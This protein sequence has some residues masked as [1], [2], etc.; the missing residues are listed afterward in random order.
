M[1]EIQ[2]PSPVLWEK[3]YSPE[4]LKDARAKRDVRL[5][6]KKAAEDARLKAEEELKASR[7]A[8]RDACQSITESIDR[9][10]HALQ[11]KINR[12]SMTK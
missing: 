6:K 9:K 7:Q 5:A 4:A 10:M 12:S 8:F 3:Y 1:T 2:G 11:M